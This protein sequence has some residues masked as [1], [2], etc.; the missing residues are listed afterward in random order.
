ML[1]LPGAPPGREALRLSLDHE[2]QWP[3][4]DEV[5]TALRL[6]ARVIPAYPRAFNLLLADA[7]Y[8]KASFFSTFC[9]LA[10]NTLWWFSKR[11]V[12]ISIRTWL[13]YSTT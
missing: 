1:L 2:P 6:L 5:E 13:D 10:A 4:E 3:G 7:L 8:A 9:S 12:A 11:N